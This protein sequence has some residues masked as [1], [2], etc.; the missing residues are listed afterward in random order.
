MAVKS[1]GGSLCD[2]ASHC[3]V[4]ADFIKA[5]WTKDDFSFADYAAVSKVLLALIR[6]RT[7]DFRE[8]LNTVGQ[9]LGGNGEAIMYLRQW[10]R[11]H[12]FA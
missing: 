5:L 8:M 10:A 9:L 1:L 6:G 12:F 7:D 4:T 2:P 3:S 11:G